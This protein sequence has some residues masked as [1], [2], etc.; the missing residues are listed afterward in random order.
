[1]WVLVLYQQHALSHYSYSVNKNTCGD[2]PA[3]SPIIEHH[4]GPSREAVPPNPT[5]A[6]RRRDVT[7]NAASQPPAQA[8]APS[9]S[10]TTFHVPLAGGLVLRRK[11]REE[12]GGRRKRSWR[13]RNRNS[14]DGGV[15]TGS[16]LITSRGKSHEAITE[17][18]PA[19]TGR[20]S[21]RRSPGRSQG[22]EAMA[23]LSPPIRGLPTDEE[24]SRILKVKVVA[25][26]GLAKKDILGASDPYTKLSLYDP[27]SGE[28]TSLQTK[29]IKKVD[30]RK[31]RLLFEVFDEN[32]LVS[33]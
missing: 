7:L 30:P 20:S 23:S 21:D 10:K 18:E 31:H 17:P 4:S 13:R 32:R 5:P 26:I 24:E 25:G 2:E 12:T 19:H 6:G 9:P 29:T 22:R 28:I 14:S 27:A 11:R 15:T 16:Y 8:Q 33:Y 3:H 1:M